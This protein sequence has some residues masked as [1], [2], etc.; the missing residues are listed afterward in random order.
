MSPFAEDSTPLEAEA[1]PEREESQATVALPSHARSRSGGKHADE[2]LR[3]VGEVMGQRLE[4]AFA[5]GSYC[6]PDTATVS[7]QVYKQSV[8]KWACQASPIQQTP[9]KV[10]PSKDSKLNSHPL[11]TDSET[12]GHRFEVLLQP[13]TSAVPHA[14]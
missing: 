9:K 7:K 11:C 2:L 13:P 10:W 6:N 14:L 5:C 3:R 12:T 1:L 8:G 4:Q